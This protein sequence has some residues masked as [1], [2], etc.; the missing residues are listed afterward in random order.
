MAVY[1]N[2]ISAA[3]NLLGILLVSKPRRHNPSFSPLS[4]LRMHL[5][6]LAVMLRTELIRVCLEKLSGFLG[7]PTSNVVECHGGDVISL[8]LAHQGI[9]FE[10][11]LEL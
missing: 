6:A 9:V 10:E 1:T 3:A 7:M 5:A 8:A 2:Y 4:S 11:I